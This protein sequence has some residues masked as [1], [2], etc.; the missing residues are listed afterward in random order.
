MKFSER[1]KTFRKNSK[2]SQEQLSEKLKVSRQAIT[3]WETGGGIPDIENLIAISKL[4]DISL[5]ELLLE[6]NHSTEKNEYNYRSMTEY[7]I[8]ELKHFDISLVGAYSVNVNSHKSEKLKILL[9]SNTL[10]N[11]EQGIKT[12]LDDTKK[13]IDVFIDQ[14]ENLTLA[15]IKENLI[16]KILIPENY[17]GNVELETNINNLYIKNI[18][19]PKFEFDGK[20]K[21]ISI[22]KFK[23]HMEINSNIDMIINC[24][25]FNGKIDVNQI[26]SSSTINIFDEKNIYARTRGIRNKIL[27]YKN[28]KETESFSDKNSSNQIELNGIKSE[29][30]INKME[31][32]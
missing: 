18:E 20:V 29:L 30:I 15:E 11:L 24:K 32:I 1:L 10:S 17:L 23:G 14:K 6:E 26:K 28:G 21:N 7:D 8:D 12:K 4:L 22:D 9:L 25:E 27:F 2:L 13:R 31:D 19:S 16:V 3:K 5:D